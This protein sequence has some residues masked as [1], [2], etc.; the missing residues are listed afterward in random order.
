[1]MATHAAVTGIPAKAEHKLYM[2]NSSTALFYDLRIVAKHQMDSNTSQA[3]PEY[4]KN[5]TFKKI[6]LTMLP[7]QFFI[8]VAVSA[9]SAGNNPP[10]LSDFN[11][12]SFQSQCS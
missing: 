9:P 7:A 2:D 5:I 4:D 6:F 11:H 1:M 10:T 3:T 8:C 12:L